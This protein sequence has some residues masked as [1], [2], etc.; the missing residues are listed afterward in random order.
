MSRPGAPLCET[1]YQ[2]FVVLFFSPQ[3]GPQFRAHHVMSQARQAPKIQQWAENKEENRFRSFGRARKVAI[4][5]VLQ[6]ALCKTN[7]CQWMKYRLKT[8]RG[9]SSSSSYVAL[10]VF[11]TADLLAQVIK[12]NFATQSGLL[13]SSAI[14]RIWQV[15][16]KCK[17]HEIHIRLQFRIS[18]VAFVIGLGA[19]SID[20]YRLCLPLCLRMTSR[21]CFCTTFF[22]CELF[23]KY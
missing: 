5:N 20:G 3:F 8:A 9:L 17:F 4:W 6:K 10:T 23:S 1:C 13:L 15:G 22:L 2:I 11:V 18:Q 12:Q 19:K 14:I 16:E 7:A 21:R